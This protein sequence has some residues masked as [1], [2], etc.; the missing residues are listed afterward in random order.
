MSD[1]H[2]TNAGHIITA[3]RPHPDRIIEAQRDEPDVDGNPGAVVI[4]VVVSIVLLFAFALT[5]GL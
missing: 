5:W 3:H 4:G 1:L 2:P